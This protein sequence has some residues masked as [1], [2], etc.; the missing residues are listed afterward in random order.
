MAKGR[1]K[2]IHYHYK[3]KL[4][5]G[6]TVQKQTLYRD[7]VTKMFEDQLK[8]IQDRNHIQKIDQNNAVSSLSLARRS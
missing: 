3:I 4:D 5:I 6:H 7:L 1:F 2:P 8:W